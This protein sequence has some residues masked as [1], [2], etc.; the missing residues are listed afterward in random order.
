[1]E[2]KERKSTGDAV[3]VEPGGEGE[4]EG[5]DAEKGEPH[6]EEH[7]KEVRVLK[8]HQLPRVPHNCRDLLWVRT[9]T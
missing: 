5:D 9:G 6:R 2:K 4:G 1:M 3:R 7:H 8:P